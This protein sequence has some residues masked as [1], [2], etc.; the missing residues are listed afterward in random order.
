[1]RPRDQSMEGVLRGA[2]SPSWAEATH[3]LPVPCLLRDPCIYD[4][5]KPKVKNCSGIRRSGSDR[6]GM[7]SRGG[8]WR[9]VLFCWTFLGACRTRPCRSAANRTPRSCSGVAT[10]QTQLVSSDGMP[11]NADP[12][13][14][15]SEAGQHPGRAQCEV[16]DGSVR[17]T[18]GRIL[19]ALPEALAG[20]CP[21]RQ[22]QG[23]TCRY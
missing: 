18:E 23:L 21:Q 5:S 10:T 7:R 15:Q 1:M 12:E 20:S 8:I 16:D 13:G 22:E 4:R 17:M 11:P 6:G 19:V 2:P 3:R 14:K 9:C